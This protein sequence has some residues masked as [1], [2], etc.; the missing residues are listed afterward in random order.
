MSHCKRK[1]TKSHTNGLKYKSNP[2]L[3]SIEFQTNRTN[4][5]LYLDTTYS[6]DNV[7]DIKRNLGDVPLESK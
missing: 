1:D 5:C 4:M 6:E 2:D 3:N 7:K